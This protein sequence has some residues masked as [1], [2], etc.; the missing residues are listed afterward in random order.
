VQAP[1]K[2]ELVIN[3][4]TAKALGLTVPYLW[5]T[6]AKCP[7]YG[8]FGVLVGARQRPGLPGGYSAAGL[9]PV[10]WRGS[11]PLG[12]SRDL[13]GSPGRGTRD[14]REEARQTNGAWALIRPNRA[15]IKS[16]IKP[17]CDRRHRPPH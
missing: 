5:L 16:K 9:K 17:K 13:M 2:Y 11:A 14:S 3:L 15:E 6:H 1:T 4:K 10:R 7:K 8:A 12:E